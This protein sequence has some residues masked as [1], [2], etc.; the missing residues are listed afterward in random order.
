MNRLERLAPLI[1]AMP[2]DVFEDFVAAAAYSSGDQTIYA[3]L[4]EAER[5]KIDAAAARMEAGEGLPYDTVKARMAAKLKA[6]G[7]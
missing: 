5:A 4:S 7:V 2:D 3:S 1:D 6:S